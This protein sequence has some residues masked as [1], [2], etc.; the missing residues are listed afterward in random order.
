MSRRGAA[1]F[2]GLAV[3][4]GSLSAVLVPEADATPAPSSAHAAGPTQQRATFAGVNDRIAYVKHYRVLHTPG[5]DERSDIFTVRPNGTDGKRLTRSHDVGLPIW[6]P[7][8]RR[9][10]Y[11][12][13]DAVWVMKAD[14]SGKKKVADGDL[15]GWMPSGKQILVVR[16]IS[17]VPEGTDPTWVLHTLATG[18]EE[19]LPIDLPLVADLEEPYDNYDEWSIAAAPT[20]SP[21][22]ETLAFE[23]LRD[24]YADDGY[25]YYFGSFFTIRLDGTDLTRV[26]HYTYSF[27]GASWSPDS[28]E[29]AYWESE[30]RAFCDGSIRSYRLNGNVGSVSYS[31]GCPEDPDWSPDGRKIVFTNGSRLQIVN[32]NGTHL[33][34]V[35]P[36]KEG[37]Y[38]YAPDWRRKP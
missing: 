2:L 31:K 7:S 9:I 29:I 16:N 13:P 8:G 28:D 12:R 21:D 6:A 35:L 32:P 5:P 15:V 25:D 24:D 10:A 26:G 11:Q 36:A 18:E 3:A 30:P 33:K 23:M 20:L 14:G 1:A 22:G 27:G 4:A 37:V 19:S 17:G 38:L 34:T